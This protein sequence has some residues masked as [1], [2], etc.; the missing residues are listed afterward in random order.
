MSQTQTQKLH[1]L[2]LLSVALT[3]EQKDELLT[4]LDT[5]TP[6]KIEK[7]EAIFEAEQETKNAMLLKKFQEHPEL[8]DAYVE[9]MQK[10]SQQAF[11][12]TE[13]EQ[14]KAEDPEAVLEKLN[15]IP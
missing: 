7:L 8:A 3:D 11:K 15:N 4:Q 2:I 6:S 14:R 10:I 5:F 12:N 9:K 1:H 13:K